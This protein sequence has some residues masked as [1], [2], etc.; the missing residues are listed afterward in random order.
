MGFINDCAMK[1]HWEGKVYLQEF[2]TLVL[3]WT[4]VSDPVPIG[5]GV[6][7]RLDAVLSLPGI[8]LSVCSHLAF[9]ISTT[10]RAIVWFISSWYSAIKQLIL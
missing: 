7:T 4:G 9:S 3:E 2:L 1:K 10:D 8:I 5:P 6:W